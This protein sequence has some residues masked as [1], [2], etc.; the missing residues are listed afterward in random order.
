MQREVGDSPWH[1]RHAMAVVRSA[2]PAILV[3][4]VLLD[5]VGTGSSRQVRRQGSV[6]TDSGKSRVDKLAAD[7]GTA[8]PV[9]P[10]EP[11]GSGCDEE[12]KE[13]VKRV[14]TL[15]RS[16]QAFASAALRVALVDLVA[17][18]HAD[19]ELAGQ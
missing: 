13:F 7:I 1:W 9:R 6:G 2:A 18:T 4:I 5:A 19:C 11:D 12:E 15:P 10:C 3:L 14:S 16:F 8:P 17:V